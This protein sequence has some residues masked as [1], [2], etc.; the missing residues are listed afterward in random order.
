MCRARPF[1]RS[2][3]SG[4]RSGRRPGV[5]PGEASGR[6]RAAPSVAAC[7]ERVQFLPAGTSPVGWKPLAQRRGR[8]AAGG[9]PGPKHLRPAGDR[10]RLRGS[11]TAPLSPRRLP[12]SRGAPSSRVP[13]AARG[14]EFLRGRDPLWVRGPQNTVRLGWSSAVRVRLSGLDSSS[15]AGAGK[16]A[17]VPLGASVGTDDLMGEELCPASNC[18]SKLDGRQRAAGKRVP[19]RAASLPAGGWGRTDEVV[20][21]KIETKCFLS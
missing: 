7:A 9:V 21:A 18:C 4:P 10:N 19:D 8:C 6:G 14:P 11:E 20:A 17:S 5:G 12:A 16:A 1:S 3:A 13:A 2:S 15:R